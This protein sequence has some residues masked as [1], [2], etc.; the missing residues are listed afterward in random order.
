MD[1][2]FLLFDDSSRMLYIPKGTRKTDGL[3]A[4][5]VLDTTE[6]RNIVLVSEDA[7]SERAVK[8]E[9]SIYRILKEYPLG[10]DIA[11]LIKKKREV[12]LTERE[13]D[14]RFSKLR[15]PI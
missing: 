2:I 13:L 7:A 14:A 1:K 15:Y 4:Q 9:K 11:E 8:G 3:A 12:D 6:H 5:I 10:D